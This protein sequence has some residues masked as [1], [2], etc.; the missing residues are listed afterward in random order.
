MRG[1]DSTASWFSPEELSSY[2]EFL[3]GNSARDQ[4][5]FMTLLKMIGE[6]NIRNYSIYTTRLPDGHDYLLSYF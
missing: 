6:C 5:N 1:D 3:T 2:A 4:R